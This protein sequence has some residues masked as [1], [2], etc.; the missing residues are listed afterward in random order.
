MVGSSSVFGVVEGSHQ[1][2]ILVLV[3]C[4]VLPLRFFGQV[5]EVRE[6]VSGLEGLSS[7]RRR[8]VVLDSAYRELD[9]VAV[10]AGSVRLRC[11]DEGAECSGVGY[12]LDEARRGIRFV[13]ADSLH[14]H[15][16][17]V[18]Y[19]VILSPL[20]F[21]YRG[22]SLQSGGVQDGDGLGGVSLG[23]DRGGDAK[24]GVGGK[25]NG[26]TVKGYAVEQV[27]MGGGIGSESST[28]LNLH[29]WGPLSESVTMYGSVVDQGLPFQASGATS[30]VEALER[31][32]LR[33]EG[34]RWY[35]EGGDVELVD[36]GGPYVRYVLAVRGLQFCYGKDGE[37]GRPA[38]PWGEGGVADSAE[39]GG[40]GYAGFG[41]ERGV[42]R[43]VDIAALD[44]VQ[45]P[46]TL[47]GHHGY[48]RVMVLAGSERV[49]VD[50]ELVVRGREGD[51]VID[52]N[53][54][55]ITF[56]ARCPITGRSRIRVI[57]KGLESPYTVYAAHG[58]GGVDVGAGGRLMVDAV[59]RG[60]ASGSLRV[61]GGGGVRAALVGLGSGAEGAWV[62]V[63]EGEGGYVLVDT[64]VVDGCG[65][66]VRD[67]VYVYRGEG[68]GVYSVPFTHV[69]Y[70]EGDY[71]V[72]QDSLNREYYRWVAPG[73]GVRGGSYRA[74]RYVATPGHQTLV[75]VGY[76]QQWGGDS[77]FMSEVRVVHGYH[78][79]NALSQR[80]GGL[81]DHGVGGYIRHSQPI[82][83]LGGAE[84]LWRSEVQ[85]G[86]LGLRGMEEYFS[87]EY[88]RNWGLEGACDGLG[89]GSG[90][91]RLVV[92]GGG[93]E[94]SLGVRSIYRRGVFG[95][96]GVVEQRYGLGGGWTYDGS[97]V[98]RGL[99]S[100]DSGGVGARGHGGWG[101][102][103]FTGRLGWG[104]VR[105]GLGSEW[106][107]GVGAGEG[108]GLGV[109]PAR[110]VLTCL[111][112][113]E[114]GGGEGYGG[115]GEV[116]YTYD[117]PFV[118][119]VGVESGGGGVAVH[120]LTQGVSGYL[121][122]GAGSE[123]RGRVH[124][125]SVSRRARVRRWGEVEH[126]V[127]GE[128]SVN[129]GFWGDRVRLGG[130]WRLS[131]EVRPEWQLHFIR[132]GRGRGAYA[133][134]DFNG[135]GVEQLEEFVV[136]Q[137]GDEGSYMLQRVPGGGGLRGV[138]RGGGTY[139]LS[140]SG[141]AGHGGI[142]QGTPC[143]ERYDA[144]VVF[145]RESSV[146]GG[147]W[148]RPLVPWGGD[149]Q[150]RDGAL[151]VS[152]EVVL[153]R[154]SRP[155]EVVYGYDYSREGGYLVQGRGEVRHESHRGGVKFPFGG[156]HWLGGVV[157]GAEDGEV[158]PYSGDGGGLSLRYAGGEVE[159]GY[160]SED[161]EG[162]GRLS[163]GYHRA[164]LSVGGRGRWWEVAAEGGGRLWGRVE[165]G[166]RVTYARMG[167]DLGMGPLVYRAVKGYGSGDNVTLGVE[168]KYMV[169]RQIS[170]ECSYQ[171]RLLG[172]MAFQHSGFFSV[173]GHF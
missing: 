167:G 65:A 108:G 137:Y 151:R 16:V 96:G 140:L 165:V 63:P 78:R 164:E 170:V 55:E 159:Y 105:L 21:E 1:K 141:R 94:S 116:K 85:W 147:G 83:S 14:G 32:Y 103:G 154:G 89:G 73:C 104:S 25:S 111:G 128:V 27:G 75:S 57:Y 155:V 40:E 88:Y 84:V 82:G 134:K 18:D 68:K 72:E 71:V 76:R 13:Y 126:Q 113:V 7:L 97:F 171:G 42:P 129:Q 77:L 98:G 117:H 46:Y 67:S 38:G 115:E 5:G 123:V 36:R 100:R 60:E 37:N 163:V 31:L 158:R 87:R 135:D 23:L 74:G 35:V 173:R 160:G 145:S 92:R 54:G 166:G 146:S 153:N 132:V 6:G 162:H 122:G 99:F 39:V 81:D 19:R 56:T 2:R 107:G 93:G 150:E 95:Y 133:W 53:L 70:G 114:L 101:R 62:V 64:V 106:N 79:R 30:R 142:A 157:R 15:T 43:V 172:V 47:P 152:G 49:Y 66:R 109:L 143:W 144:T 52:Y 148:W 169:S 69:G 61:G 161:G 86:S 51:Y 59:W 3:F 91:H 10:V 110:W 29:F 33:M 120:A 102:L 130:E 26:F 118:G 127:M 45:G 149:V 28:R 12:E 136:S 112:R 11:G 131:R 58:G 90:D 168:L 9:S 44:G 124:W 8:W 119:G 4:I 17:R 125:R 121:R 34:R 24:S 48:A 41:M 22:Y 156:G 138:S 139:R 80:G 20:E 50:G